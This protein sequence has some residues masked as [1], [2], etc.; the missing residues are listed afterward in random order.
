MT[1]R[2]ARLDRMWSKRWDTGGFESWD[3]AYGVKCHIPRGAYVARGGRKQ[4]PRLYY[5]PRWRR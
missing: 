3:P 2:E 5:S 1:P 4:L